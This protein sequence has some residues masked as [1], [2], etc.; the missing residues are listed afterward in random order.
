MM[1]LL[2]IFYLSL[3]LISISFCLSAAMAAYNGQPCADSQINPIGSHLS[4][5]RVVSLSQKLGTQL[6][7]WFNLLFIILNFIIDFT[8]IAFSYLENSFANKYR[9]AAFFTET[10]NTKSKRSYFP[11]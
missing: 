8:V 1:F 11:E 4:G 7:T 6:C 9:D 5:G 3:P 2:W 10:R